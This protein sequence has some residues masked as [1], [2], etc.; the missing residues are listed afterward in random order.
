MEAGL[1][2][3]D[4]NPWTVDARQFG[5]NDQQACFLMPELL[6]CKQRLGQLKEQMSINENS[7][8]SKQLKELDQLISECES[9]VEDACRNRTIDG[10][11]NH[12]F[13]QSP[14]TTIQTI[15]RLN[16]AERLIIN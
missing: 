10:S 4:R 1:F 5:I 15:S 13:G 16:R 11:R 7:L 12:P 3:G 2:G 14:F 6:S 9:L 8:S